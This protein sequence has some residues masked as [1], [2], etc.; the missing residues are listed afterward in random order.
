MFYLHKSV[1]TLQLYSQ[2]SHSF[3]LVLGV[4]KEE[5]KL[6][7]LHTKEKF[8]FTKKGIPACC[9]K[10]RKTDSKF[11]LNYVYIFKEGII[12]IYLYSQRHMQRRPMIAARTMQPMTRIITMIKGISSSQGT[13]FSTSPPFLQ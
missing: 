13:F 11:F 5:L 9:R 6:V 7:T 8:I 2:H 10:S 3:S 4:C 1:C 12:S